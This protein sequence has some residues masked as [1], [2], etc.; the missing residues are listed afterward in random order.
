MRDLKFR[1][2]D[3]VKRIVGYEKWYP[4]AMDSKNFYIAN[5]CWLYSAD[6][7]YWNPTPISHRTKDEW[8][9]LKDKNGVEIFESDLVDWDGDVYEVRFNEGEWQLFN[10]GDMEGDRPSLYRISSP[11]Q[12]RMVIVGNIYE[13]K[14]R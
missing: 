4:G 13:N 2:L 6:G 9:G 7:E 10:S 5:P 8:T 1:L 11:K 12:S 3:P 14:K